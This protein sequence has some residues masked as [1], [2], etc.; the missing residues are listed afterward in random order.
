[1]ETKEDILD[2]NLSSNMIEIVNKN[3]PLRQWIYDAM[4]EYY[5]VK[6]EIEEH[7]TVNWIE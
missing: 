5:E 6:T 1:M 4:E 3:P 2:D 7:G